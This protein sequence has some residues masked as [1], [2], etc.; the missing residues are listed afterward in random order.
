VSPVTCN[1]HTTTT[2][3]NTTTTNTNTT[4]ANTYQSMLATSTFEEGGI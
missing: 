2:T 3:T 1:R 4:T